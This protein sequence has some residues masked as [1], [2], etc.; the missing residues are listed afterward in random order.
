[1]VFSFAVNH[2]TL[3]DARH[4]KELPSFEG[5]HSLEVLRVD[6]CNLGHIPE[7]LCH[8]SPKLKSL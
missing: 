7:N 5:C 6:H 8:H 2:R 1:M 4:L 3:S